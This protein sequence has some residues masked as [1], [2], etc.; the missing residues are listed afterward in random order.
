MLPSNRL[1]LSRLGTLFVAL[2]LVGP[3]ALYAAGDTS[4]APEPKE[5]DLQPLPPVFD[6]AVPESVADLRAIESHVKQVLARV[7]PAVVNVRI[8]Q[9]QG[10]GVIVSADGYV[11]TA[12]HVSGQPGKDAT[13]T[14][15]DGRKLKGKTL[16]ANRGIDSGMVKITVE[17]RFPFVDLGKSSE[18]K[19]GAWCIAIGHPGGYRTGRSPVVRVGR[20]LD[21]GKSAIRTDCT[22]VGGDSG[23]PLFDMHGR[24]IGIHS[25]IGGPITAN[26]HVPVDTYRDTWDRL[27]KGESWGGS[28]FGQ[29]T[30]RNTPYLGVE[31]DL[32]SDECKITR[33]M[34][35]S[36][37]EKAGVRVGD[38]VL[39]CAGRRIGAFDD[40]RNLVQSRRPNEELALEVRRGDQTVNLKIVIGKRPG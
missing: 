33:V 21:L 31:G 32:D 29:P 25:R 34:A 39:R 37:A 28:L 20:I 19:K 26:V 24:V 12:G 4:Q 17:G 36:P 22:L 5:R 14:M 15:P 11:L 30:R 40:L 18:V 16:G 9:G 38:V 8:G 6:K 23:G 35:G 13:I 27:A 1:F 7:T 2:W 3:L 10:S